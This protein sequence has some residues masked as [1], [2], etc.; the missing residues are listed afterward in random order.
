MLSPC[1]SHEFR[2]ALKEEP[3]GTEPT[4]VP[5]IPL[6]PCAACSVMF[7]VLRT[8]KEQICISTT[9]LPPGSQFEPEAKTRRA[10][11]HRPGMGFRSA[12]GLVP[13]V[14]A[15]ILIG[16]GGD[17]IAQ[18]LPVARFEFSTISSPKVGYV[19]FR[20]IITAKAVDGTTARSFHS[21]VTLTATDNSGPV[22]VEGLTPLQFSN[23]QWVGLIGVN[24][25]N[26]T[27]TLT[28]MDSSG[29]RGDAGPITIEAPP[30][31]VR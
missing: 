6:I 22:P 28:V 2:C 9:G 3:I 18:G 12:S 23:G 31:R 1:A 27:V 30:F 8:L 25:S 4:L 10:V 15:I 11:L 19:P 29:H 26:T 7:I 20:V 24:A 17:A 5:L 13:L 16:F 21:T 14:V